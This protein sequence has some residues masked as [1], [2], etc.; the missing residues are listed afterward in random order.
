MERC[1]L[2]A[3]NEIGAKLSSMCIFNKK[4]QLDS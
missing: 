4:N 1:E 2:K 3:M